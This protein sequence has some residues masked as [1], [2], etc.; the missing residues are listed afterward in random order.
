MENIIP[1]KL[2]KGDEV[3]IIAPSTSMNILSEETISIAKKRLEDMGLVVTFGKNVNKV[4]NDNFSCASID[5]RVDDLHE[6]FKDNNVKCILTVIGGFNVNQILDYIDYDL[7]KNNPKIICGYSDITALLNAIYSKTGLIT[8]HGPFFSTFGMKKGFD[9]IEDYFKKIFFKD[10][11]IEIKSSNKWSEDSWYIN[12]DNRTFIDNEGIIVINKGFAS[13]KIIGGNLC[14]LNLLQGTEYMPDL[15]NTVLFIEDDDLAGEDYLREFD[16][17]LQ[18]LLHASKDK[19]I[20]GIV[21]GRSQSSTK[22]NYD[23]WKLII[24]TKKELENIP[25]I[26]NADFGHTYPMFTFPIG[27]NVEINNNKISIKMK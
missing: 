17:D 25:V 6:A 27:L 3:R 26:I 11:N 13:G 7:I 18:S 16:R 2:K 14:T 1:K 23:K 10:N 21:I 12:Q 22:M 9:Y 15:D 4:M 8:Y 5:D 20:N 19:K 24:K